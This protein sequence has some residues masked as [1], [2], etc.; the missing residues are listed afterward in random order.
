M[1]CIQSQGERSLA[2]GPVVSEAKRVAI[3]TSLNRTE[4]LQKAATVSQ[5]GWTFS[6]AEQP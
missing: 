2:Q 4:S 5:L 1:H 3:L 6:L